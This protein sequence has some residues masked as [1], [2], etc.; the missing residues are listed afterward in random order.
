MHEGDEEC[1]MKVFILSIVV[2]VACAVAA[3]QVATKFAVESSEMRYA[4]A[5]SRP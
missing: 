3:E 5:T 2:A 1:G 4:S